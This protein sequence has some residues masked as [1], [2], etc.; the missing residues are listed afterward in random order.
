[1]A[2]LSNAAA[3]AEATALAPLMNSGF[4]ELYSGPQ[5]A[6]AN[7]SLGA[8]VL[9]V[10]L[11]FS[12]TAFLAPPVAGLLVAFPIVS[13]VGVSTGTATF[14]RIYQS[15]GTSVVMDVPLGTT[16]PYEIILNTLNI[17]SGSTV[18]M[19]SFSHQIPLAGPLT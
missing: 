16:A 13:G 12:A 19:S 11:G 9:L 4:I 14:A 1:M 7:T 17:V 8:N 10:T 3:N 5:P 15:N 2:N 6:T 18:S